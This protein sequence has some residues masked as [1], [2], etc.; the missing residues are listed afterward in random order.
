MTWRLPAGVEIGV[1]TSSWQ[2]EG[3]VGQ[4]GRCIWDDFAERPGAIV[5]ACTADPACDHVHRLDED[6]DLLAWLGVGAYRFSI[7][8]PRVIPDGTGPTSPAGVDFYDRLVDGLLQRGIAPVAT[9]YHWDLPSPLQTQGGWANRDTA[10]RFAD[11]AGAV[12]GHLG[13]R[14]RRW[15]TINEPWCA[16]FLGHASGVHAP[17]ITNPDAA[18]RAAH[19]LLLAHGW[20]SQQLRSRG[21]AEV[22]IALNLIPV[23]A[24]SGAAEPARRHVD[25]IQ[26]RLFLE[27]LA[28]R[29][30]P[31][32]LIDA[33]TALT[34]WRC[35]QPG[36]Q[37]AIAAP[38][39][40]L[41]VNYYTVARVR[42]GRNPQHPENQEGAA[43][44]GAPAL[45]FAPR[46]PV[47]Q[48]DWEVAPS[49]LLA[50]LR[51]AAAA[52]PGVPLAVTE[53]GAATA[54]TDTG[55]AIH[56]PERIAYLQGHLQA[57]A[58]ARG[59]GL[60]V[61]GYFVWSLL[62]N[63]EWAWGWTRRFGLVRV[64]PAHLARRPKDSALWLREV[65][66]VRQIRLTGAPGPPAGKDQRPSGAGQA[67]TQRSP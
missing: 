15:A 58:E 8:W 36:D 52:L 44:P 53:N 6:L 22:G 67:G 2:I 3:G 32:D 39:D 12:A 56:D 29:G 9:L 7:S 25:A 30:V 37:A 31:A 57:L 13:D 64:D 49:G 46:P 51:M 21:P 63:I 27:P 38:L 65:L 24:D 66:R 23:L 42:D 40:W 17:G 33:T 50:A 10:A 11:Y 1:A 34:D 5:D 61:Q 41:G 14:V 47:T 62:D 20:A 60:P 28:G 26:N 16:A 45:H 48:M 43:F 19:H 4:R 18:F 59:E 55:A 54:E 35:I